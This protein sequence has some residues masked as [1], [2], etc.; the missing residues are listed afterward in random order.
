MLMEQ[1]FYDF[2]FSLTFSEVDPLITFM[3]N[4]IF[5]KQI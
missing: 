3:Q 2:W 4:T 5:R 1:V